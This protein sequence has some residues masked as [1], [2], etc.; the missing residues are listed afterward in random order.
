MKKNKVIDVVIQQEWGISKKDMQIF[1]ETELKKMLK[2]ANRISGGNFYILDYYNQRIIV[3]SPSAW[4]LCGYS[5]DLLEQE[6]FGFFNRIL[7]EQ[8]IIRNTK[9]NNA[10]YRLFYN[11]PIE[12]RDDLVLDYDLIVQT[13]NKQEFVLHNKLASYK[14]CRNGNMWLGLCRVSPSS[15]KRD[16]C[17]VN[18]TNTKTGEVFDYVDSLFVPSSKKNLTAIELNI[19]TFMIKDST[20]KQMCDFLK[21]PSTTFKRKKRSLYD[22]LQADSPAGAIHNAHLLGVI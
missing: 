1:S 3:D 14:T 21:I 18:A 4:I 9:I 17:M 20:E 15:N 2:A 10:A 16:R 8:E 12:K 22:K 19:L 7:K 13:S 11:T 5:M 6:G